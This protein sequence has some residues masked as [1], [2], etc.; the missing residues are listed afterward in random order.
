MLLSIALIVIVGFVLGGV[1]QRLGIPGLIGM[2][3]AGVVLGPTMF[4]LIDPKVLLIAPD[5]RQMA[6]IVIL[7]RAGLALDLKDLQAIG[8]PAVL[9]SFVPATFELLAVMG[10]SHFL[11]GLSWLDGAILGAILAAVSPAVV[12]P[13]MLNLMER[14]WGQSHKVPQLVM[15]GASADDLYVIMVFSILLA[16]ATGSGWSWTMILELPVSIVLG[17][18]LG[19]LLGWGLVLV[20]KRIHMRDTVK[21]LVMLS[22]SFLMVAVEPLIPSIPYSGLLG[23]MSLGVAILHRYPLLAKRITGKFAKI[24]VASELMLFALVGAAVDFSVLGQAGFLAFMV[25]VGALMIRMAGVEV[26]L[27]KTPL[28]AK[29]RLFVA[30]AYLP[31]ATVQA[32]IGSIPLAMGLPSGGLLL[33]IAVLAIV[34]SAPMGALAIDHTAHRL[35]GQSHT[36]R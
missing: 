29:E 25:V 32:A 35:L 14:Q 13:R 11:L 21:V 18:V 6:L 22:A 30:L 28:T 34:I 12:V 2:M 36:N 33:S 9:L 31:K 5:L 24:W 19:Y 26:S 3:A 7:L 23:V 10:L 17:I 27:L 15:A 4:N 16:V 8:R 1:L 20:F